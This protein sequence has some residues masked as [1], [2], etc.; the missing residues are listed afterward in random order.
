MH[1]LPET[2]PRCALAATIA[3]LGL[4]GNL[5]MIT[6]FTAFGTP[7]DRGHEDRHLCALEFRWV[8]ICFNA[9]WSQVQTRGR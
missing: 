5:A 9:P 4:I 2:G 6:M 7:I 1:W 3:T 8:A